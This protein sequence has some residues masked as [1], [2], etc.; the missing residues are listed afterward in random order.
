MGH[1]GSAETA[2]GDMF[3]IET[4]GGAGDGLGVGRGEGV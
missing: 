2:P 1:I 3:V 4:L